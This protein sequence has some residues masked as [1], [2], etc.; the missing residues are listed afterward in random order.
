M[1]AM[2]AVP[3]V[4]FILL[5]MALRVFGYG[6]PTDFFVKIDGREAYTTNQ[7]FGWR[8]FP[9]AIA[10][11]PAVCEL[12]ADKPE[13]TYRIFVLGGSAAM[14]TPHPAFS[15]GRML[16][17]MLQ[18][19]F[20]DRRFEVVN[21]AMTAVNSHV[22]L[23]IARDCADRQADLFVVYMGNNEVVGPYGSGTV[24]GDFSG[25]LSVIQASMWLKSTRSGQLL[26]SVLGGGGAPAQWEG[27]AMFLGR[28]VPADDPRMEKVYSHF[29]TNL[30][31][32]C[33]VAR[34]SGADVILCTVA[35]NLKDCAPFAAVHR[36]DLPEADRARWKRLYRAGIASSEAN[37]HARAAGEFLQAARID[38]RRADLQFRLGRCF[39]ELGQLDN[40]R[41]HFVLARDL[42]ALR[43]RADTRINR[44]I[45]EAAGE[46]SGRGVFLVDVERAFERSDPARHGLCGRE[47]FHEHVHMNPEGNYLLAKVVF[48]RI[49]QL[50]PN[51]AHGVS[52][53]SGAPPMERCFDLIALTDWDRYRVARHVLKLL[54]RPPFTNQLDHDEQLR[55]QRERL[56]Q[57]Q[58]ECTSP[59]ALE[60]A[61]RRYVEAINRAPDDLM[62]RRNFARLLSRR[63][64]YRG[65]ARQWR[66]L[67]A[68]FPD[69]AE[70][71]ME[72]GTMLKADGKPVEA[73]A[74]LRHALRADPRVAA[75]ARFNMATIRLEQG[76]LEEAEELLRQALAADPTLAEAHNT[77]GAIFFKRGD[78]DAA[79]ECFRKALDVDPDLIRGHSNLAYALGSRGDPAGA[80]A[81]YREVLR[82]DP[83]NIPARHNL[84]VALGK[85]GRTAEAV[86]Q[87]QQVLRRRG[88]Y[89][90]TVVALGRVRASHADAKFRDGLGAI[91]LILPACR[92]TGYRNPVLLDV[93]A[94]AYAEAGQFNDAVAAAT[95]AL[96]LA[97]DGG[98]K[99]LAS[100]IRERLSLYRRG[101]PYRMPAADDRR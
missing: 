97:R 63:G 23:A 65:A 48:E 25:S 13:G 52:P 75:G 16:G 46:Q 101:E 60:E 82:I 64:D 69:M 51:G 76:R 58:A 56:G 9:P 18:E 35:T 67:L 43:F 93:L 19:R 71:R 98:K 78:P 96:Q 27:M 37:E 59:A 15:F 95:K 41:E 47:L 22:V 85:L 88:D 31:D 70:W 20:P 50:L 55:R 44:T 11:A 81:H 30:A 24:F 3:A 66:Y 90:L 42:D 12:P 6:Y 54:K 4:F 34:E 99:E 79:I 61:Q 77:L 86:Q 100:A 62:I 73:I 29:R 80:A 89:L 21:A 45:R 84:G 8:F 72:F 17:A 2:T 83:G 49:V 26:G 74:E 14:G 7:R 5:E 32:I 40:A 36:R 87:Y 57:L 1:A 94:A 53:A 39:L 68:R 33:H 38:D 91:R 92:R 28:R 10:R